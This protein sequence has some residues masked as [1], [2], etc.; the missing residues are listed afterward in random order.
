[1]RRLLLSS[2]TLPIQ[3]ESQQDKNASKGNHFEDSFKRLQTCIFK[4]QN[5]KKKNK[6]KQMKSIQDSKP[7]RKQILG[8]NRNKPNKLQSVI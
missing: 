3:S 7:K 8:T 6:N 4:A 2:L 1:M 5:Q